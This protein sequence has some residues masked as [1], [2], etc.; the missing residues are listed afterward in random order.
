MMRNGSVPQTPA[1]NGRVLDD[2]QNFAGHV[3]DDL[4]GVAVRHHAGKAAAA[5]HAKSAGVVDDE[6][7]DAAGFGALGG[8]AGPRPAADDRLA[9]FHLGVQALE[10]FVTREEAHGCS[11]ARVSGSYMIRTTFW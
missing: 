1:K 3:H 2:G 10:N 11:G 9:G 4:V 6:K 5:R 7:I 8:D